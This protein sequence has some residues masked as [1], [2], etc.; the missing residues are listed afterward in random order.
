VT[1]DEVACEAVEAVEQRPAALGPIPFPGDLLAGRRRRRRHRSVVLTMVAV[2][3]GLVV[4]RVVPLAPPAQSGHTAPGRLGPVVARIPVGELPGSP[5][6]DGDSVWVANRADAT[7]ARVDLAADRVA[8]TVAVGPA[9]CVVVAGAG[10]VWVLGGNGAV[11][12]VDPTNDLVEATIPIGRPTAGMSELGA[13]TWRPA[14]AASARSVWITD[15]GGGE[16]VW[17]IDPDRNAVAAAVRTGRV[18]VALAASAKDVW[19]ANQDGT[20]SRIDAWSGHVTATI[21]VAAAS[22]P[23]QG[24]LAIAVGAGAVWVSDGHARVLSRIDPATDRVTA[25][26]RLPLQPGGVAATAGGVWVEHP[27]DGAVSRIDPRVDRILATLR[28]VGAPTGELG[29]AGVAAVVGGVWIA[30][31]QEDILLR[32]DPAGFSSHGAGS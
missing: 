11:T 24:E 15:P 31:L 6:T 16:L 1:L 4:L 8:A 27:V 30:A 20:V 18:P 26:I 23:P 19:A 9:P 32:V 21:R 14:L 10:A 13:V 17:R 22:D 29:T 3:L 25:S 7:I 2:T 12:R 28:V 5:V